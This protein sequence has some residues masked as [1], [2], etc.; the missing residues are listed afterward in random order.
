MGPVCQTADGP[1]PI[2]RADVEAHRGLVTNAFPQ[3]TWRKFTANLVDHWR[4]ENDRQT[5]GACRH[6]K[7]EDGGF[8][9]EAY[10][11]VPAV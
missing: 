2:T 10:D 1:R 8:C 4:A 6:Y 11:G 3:D 7:P 9:T 5:H